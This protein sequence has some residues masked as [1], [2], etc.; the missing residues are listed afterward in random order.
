MSGKF[1]TV[2]WHDRHADTT[3]H[4]FTE[5]AVAE[6]WARK[7]GREYDRHGNYSEQAYPDGELCITYSCE[8]DRLRVIDVVADAEVLEGGSAA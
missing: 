4:L 3:A 1:T 5:R 7:R 6:A 8:N 2:I